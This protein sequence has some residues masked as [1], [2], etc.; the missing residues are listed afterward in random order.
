MNTPPDSPEDAAPAAA[1]IENAHMALFRK[2]GA[3][4]RSVGTGVDSR[5]GYKL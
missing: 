3:E 1:P 5:E 4:R 2:S